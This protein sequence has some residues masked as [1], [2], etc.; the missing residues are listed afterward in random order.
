[1]RKEKLV[2]KVVLLRNVHC[3]D[4]TNG[5]LNEEYKDIKGTLQKIG[6][7]TFFGWDLCALVDGVNYK[8][9][10]LSQIQAIYR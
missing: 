1:M 10:S 4:T 2:G 9:E 5:I 6:P 7:N 3:I 8:I